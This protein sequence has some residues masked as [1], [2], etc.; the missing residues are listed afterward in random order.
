MLITLGRGMARPPVIGRVA[1]SSPGDGLLAE[2]GQ[3]LGTED[4]RL[5][6]IEWVP[7]D[8]LLTEDAVPLGTEGGQP[9]DVEIAHLSAEDDAL[10]TTESDQPLLWE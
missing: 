5:L 9:L 7:F 6:N 10:L 2:I 8:S 3:T 1:A 4:G